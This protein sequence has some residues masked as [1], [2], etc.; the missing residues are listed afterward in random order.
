MKQKNKF[1]QALGRLSVAKRHEGKSQKWI[2][3]YYQKL[4]AKRK[5]EQKYETKHE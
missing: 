4:R 1:A 5:Q 3:E 2:D